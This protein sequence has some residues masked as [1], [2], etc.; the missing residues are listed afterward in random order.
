MTHRAGVTRRKGHIV[1]K[2]QARDKVARGTPKGQTFRKKCQLKPESIKGIRIQ[3]LK[4]QLYLR[5]KRTPGSIFGKTIGLEITKRITGSSVG[6]RKIRDWTL[7]RVG[8][9]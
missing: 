7:W 9:L 3:G 6:L 5:S 4:K 2:N 1:R 8:P